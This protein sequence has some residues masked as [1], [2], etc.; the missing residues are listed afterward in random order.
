MLV[1]NYLSVHFSGAKKLLNR[2]QAYKTFFEQ[3]EGDEVKESQFFRKWRTSTIDDWAMP[4]VMGDKKTLFFCADSC[5]YGY[6]IN[7]TVIPLDLD[8]AYYAL[9]GFYFQKDSEFSSIFNYYLLKEFEH[10]IMERMKFE[11]NPERKTHPKIGMIEPE[12][13]RIQNTMFLFS[14]LAIG[15]IVSLFIAVV[16]MVINRIKGH[17]SKSQEGFLK[18]N[19]ENKRVIEIQN[20]E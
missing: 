11:Y 19:K 2:P 20:I 9:G 14:V 7:G 17:M 15:I 6:V 5:A 13:L 18:R 10:G 3:E 1:A 16:E 8:D 4:L 12:P